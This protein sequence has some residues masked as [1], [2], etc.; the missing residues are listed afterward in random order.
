MSGVRAPHGPLSVVIAT[1]PSARAIRSGIR[2]FE[3]ARHSLEIAISRTSTAPSPASTAN[4][5][6]YGTSKPAP[7]NTRTIPPGGTTTVQ[8]S[9]SAARRSRAGG[10]SNIRK[11]VAEGNPSAVRPSGSNSSKLLKKTGAKRTTRS[12]TTENLGGVLQS[13]HRPEEVQSYETPRAAPE[14]R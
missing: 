13:G 7:M 2:V 3:C 14:D 6:K 10:R 1:T 8:P 5:A 11:S 9:K 4:N 12:G